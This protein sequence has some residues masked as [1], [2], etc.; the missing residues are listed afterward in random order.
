MKSVVETKD[1]I[2]KALHDNR[3][4]LRALGVRRLGLFGSYVR[5]EQTTASDREFRL[6]SLRRWCKIL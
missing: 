2:L 4:A 6:H 3:D 1:G 5:G